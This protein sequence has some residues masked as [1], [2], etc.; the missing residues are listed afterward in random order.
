LD[1]YGGVI[2]NAH[3][4]VLGSHELDLAHLTDDEK[5]DDYDYEE[6]PF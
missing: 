2:A 5:E 3:M 1:E 6:I 4:A